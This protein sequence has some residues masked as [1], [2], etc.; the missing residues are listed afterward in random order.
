MAGNVGLLVGE[1]AAVLLHAS[2]LIFPSIR[3]SDVPFGKVL[4]SGLAHFPKVIPPPQRRS[5]FEA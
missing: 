1:V 3:L 5:K 4:L 2:K